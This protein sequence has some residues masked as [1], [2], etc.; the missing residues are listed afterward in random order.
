MQLA[1][2]EKSLLQTLATSTGNIL[3]NKKLIDAL[4]ETKAKSTTIK[5]SLLESAQLQES[6]DSQRNVYQPVA[7]RGA[8]M[9][10]LMRDLRSLNHMYQF[11]LNLFLRLFKHALEAPATPG[12]IQ[13]RTQ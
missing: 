4:S 1:E 3:E 8:L 13:A 2:L 6:L 11:S 9:F 12:D 5:E 7:E 10:F